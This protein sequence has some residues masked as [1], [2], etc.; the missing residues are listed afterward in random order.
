MDVTSLSKT[1]VVVDFGTSKVA[2]FTK[3]AALIDRVDTSI[4]QKL[5]DV[6]FEIS[7]SANILF[8]FFLIFLQVSFVMLNIKEASERF[9]ERSFSTADIPKEG[10][11]FLP[12]KEPLE[13]FFPAEF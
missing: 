7:N 13:I 6:S 4:F 3:L 10:D 11:F 12:R 1:N 9:S 5:P 2:L 8:L